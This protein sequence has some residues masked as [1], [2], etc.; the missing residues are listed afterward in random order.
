MRERY[1]G[2]SILCVAVMINEDVS[3]ACTYRYAR[4]ITR[5]VDYARERAVMMLTTIRVAI[6]TVLT[7][8]SRFVLINRGY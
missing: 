1:T 2:L 3:A 7:F 6:M 8:L 5:L 4:I